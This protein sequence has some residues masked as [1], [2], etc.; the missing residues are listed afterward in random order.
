MADPYT[1]PFPYLPGRYVDTPYEELPRALQRRV[2]AAEA[3]APP[4]E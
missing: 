4:S 2:E 1:P 3:V